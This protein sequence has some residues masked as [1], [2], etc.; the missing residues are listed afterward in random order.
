MSFPNLSAPKPS[1][2]EPP[3]PE[4]SALI[5]GRYRLAARIGQGSMGEVWRAHDERLDRT[6]AIK[7]L[8]PGATR[9]QADSLREARITA[10]LQHPNAVTV[11]DVIEQDGRTCLV[12][13]YVAGTPCSRLVTPAPADVARIGRQVADALAAAHE[14]GIVHRDVKPDNVLL[15]DD[16]QAV[17]TDFG[18]SSVIGDGGSVPGDTGVIVGTPAFLAPEVAAGAAAGFASDVFSLGATLY[19]AVEGTPP[20][21][22]D[23]DTV[24]LL[25][26]VAEGRVAE[27]ARAGALGPVLMWMLRREP[28]ARPSMSQVVAA[29]DAIA[30]GR[31]VVPPAAT[32]LLETGPHRPSGRAVALALG[33][34][35]V[36]VLGLIV[37][38]A[39]GTGDRTGS[40]V[41]Q[42]PT[43]HTRAVPLPHTQPA[44]ACV[45]DYTVTN[46]W[47]GGYQAMVTVRAG[48]EAVHGWTVT[49]DL[50]DGQTVGQVWNGSLSR[51]GSSVQVA[52]L[53]YN[54]V[55]AA[56]AS[57]TFGFL[58]SV[59]DGQAATPVVH[60]A[61]AP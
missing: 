18:I 28:G 53:D 43:A 55:M 54:A 42:P 46:S 58:G 27:P 23:P 16:G 14:L 45:A 49:L 29:L 38:I 35:G 57:T 61:A 36:A 24:A 7:L 31:P 59:A 26:R 48:S 32:M 30:D 40:P 4:P 19:A 12:M 21:G 44:A 25:H 11:H 13:S 60:C 39:I 51:D 5:A 17:L 15:T 20:F 50:P 37:G 22:T 6:V 34:I 8:L 52:S 2:P 33:G 56:D 1:A 41:A 9:I 47:P 3:V 10:K